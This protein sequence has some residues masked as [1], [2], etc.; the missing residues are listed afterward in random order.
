MRARLSYPFR[1]FLSI[2]IQ[3][4]IRLHP[5]QNKVFTIEIEKK[6]MSWNIVSSG[7]NEE[8]TMCSCL[9]SLLI[10]VNQVSYVHFVAHVPLGEFTAPLAT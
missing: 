2:E 7:A 8:F 3:S 10:L 9:P 6:L 1:S 4:L 5:D